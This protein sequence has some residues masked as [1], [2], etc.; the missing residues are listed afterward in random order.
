[1]CTHNLTRQNN[2][3]FDHMFMHNL[4]KQGGVPMSQKIDDLWIKNGK[5]RTRGHLI[6]CEI[7]G[8]ELLIRK[9][10]AKIHGGK[11]IQCSIKKTIDKNRIFEKEHGGEYQIHKARRRQLV[12]IKENQCAGC[13]E[14]NLPIYCYEFHHR[15]PKTKSFDICKGYRTWKETLIEVEK[16]DMLCLLCHKIKH[17]GD[18]RLENPSLVKEG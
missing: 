6:N 16:C 12:R 5:V 13:G 18:E 4:H 7:C 3:A 9:C 10:Q 17:R 8:K 1:M 14:K 15:D 11:C 2:D